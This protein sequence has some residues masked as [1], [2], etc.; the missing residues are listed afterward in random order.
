M[1]MMTW[2]NG[3]GCMSI[4]LLNCVKISFIGLN[5]IFVFL[6]GPLKLYWE[7]NNI[8]E[9]FFSRF[10][11][12]LIVRLKKSWKMSS[13]I[14]LLAQKFLRKNQFEKRE[15]WVKNFFEIWKITCEN[16]IEQLY[17]NEKFRNQSWSFLDSFL[18]FFFSIIWNVIWN[19]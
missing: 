2:W 12:Y 8:Y 5:W 13:T 7:S 4:Y 3:S 18:S 6:M 16:V 17:Y 9:N 19:F 11:V 1:G 14:Q 15:I 10:L